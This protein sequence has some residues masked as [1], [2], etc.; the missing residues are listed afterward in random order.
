[1]PGTGSRSAFEA[2]IRSA[3]PEMPS[4]LH[5]P[6]FEGERRRLA[7]LAYRMT[8]SVADTED[9][10]QEAVLRFRS[11]DL[12]TLRSPSRWLTTVVM[13]L[14]L[15]HLTSS[16]S[17]RE[18]YVG[19]WLPDPLIADHAPDP[20]SSWIATEDVG[21]ALILTLD[22]LTPEMRAA[23]ILRDAFDYE[24]TEIAEVVGRSAVACRQLVTR[25]RR[26]M[27]GAEAVAQPSRARDHPLVTAFWEATRKGDMENLLR[28][29]SEDIE[30]H[31]DGGGKVPAAINVIRGADKAA[32]FFAGLTRKWGSSRG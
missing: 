9:I 16:R 10:L 26:K 11:A 8:G 17:R 7:G 25:A 3:T 15:N 13:R 31:T 24:Y 12:P 22:T 30:V 20:E 32:R 29:F 27:S 28:L 23:F 1:M 19:A 21:I 14:C 6:V 2:A 5:M 4:D 18:T